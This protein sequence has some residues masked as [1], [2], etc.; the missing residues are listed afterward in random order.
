MTQS[1]PLKATNAKETQNNS[2]QSRTYKFCV[3]PGN[4]SKLII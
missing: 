2:D 4:N 3:Y 1:S